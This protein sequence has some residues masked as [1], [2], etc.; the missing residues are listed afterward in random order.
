M[1]TTPINPQGSEPAIPSDSLNHLRAIADIQNIPL[2]QAVT[3]ATNLSRLL[4]DAERDPATRVLLKTGDRVQEVKLAT[5]AEGAGKGYVLTAY[6]PQRQRD[7]VR[8]VVTVGLLALF[9]FV[10]AW[11]AW[12]SAGSKDVW[13]QTK[14]MLQIVLPALTGLIGSVLGFYFGTKNNTFGT[15]L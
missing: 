1:T 14:D 10:I 12:K 9:A 4:V 13:M 3:Q 2:P 6:N 11:A 8:L 7:Y 5:D 15:T